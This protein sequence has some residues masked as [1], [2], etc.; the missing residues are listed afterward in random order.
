VRLWKEAVLRPAA[1]F[2]GGDCAAAWRLTP[3]GQFGKG[4]LSSIEPDFMQV[5]CARDRFLV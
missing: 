5:K 3:Y 1:T 4:S 2:V